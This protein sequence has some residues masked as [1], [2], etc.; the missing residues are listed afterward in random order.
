[1]GFQPLS[2]AS[3]SGDGD[4]DATNDNTTQPASDVW[5]SRLAYDLVTATTLTEKVC[6]GHDSRGTFKGV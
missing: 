3:S 1:M 5:S 4:E 2:I 6:L